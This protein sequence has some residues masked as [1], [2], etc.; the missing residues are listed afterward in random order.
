MVNAMLRK[1]WFYEYVPLVVWVTIFV[2]D[3]DEIKDDV[4]DLL[5]I[6]MVATG[7]IVYAVVFYMALR[8]NVK[9]FQR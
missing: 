4:W 3:L 5:W 8:V 7:W 6:D 2:F 9:R 1:V